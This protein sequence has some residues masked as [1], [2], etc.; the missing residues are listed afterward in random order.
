MMY[1]LPVGGIIP[2]DDMQQLNAMGVDK[3]FPG[4]F[5]NDIAGYI[6]NWVT[7]HRSF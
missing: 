7:E 1:C 2:E 3:L 5:T 6:T 4:L